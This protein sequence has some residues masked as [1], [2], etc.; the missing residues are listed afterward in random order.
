ML[1]STLVSPNKEGQI[2][3]S[4]DIVLQKEWL[5][6]TH[7]IM[8]IFFILIYFSAHSFIIVNILRQLKHDAGGFSYKSTW[9]LQ[10]LFPLI[11]L[12]VNVELNT[13]KNREP[14]YAYEFENL[15]HKKGY[16]VYHSDITATKKKIKR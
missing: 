8:F 7:G 16:S 11:I 5:S 3:R 13:H 6:P 2:E 12:V 1:V 14:R 9:T 15:A 4:V 10:E